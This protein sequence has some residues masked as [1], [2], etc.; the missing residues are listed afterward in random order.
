MIFK[1]RSSVAI[2]S[3]TLLYLCPSLRESL[4]LSALA[5]PTPFQSLPSGSFLS[6]Q[7]LTSSVP[8]NFCYQCPQGPSSALLDLIPLD[9]FVLFWKAHSFEN[10][11]SSF[12]ALILHSLVF[13]CWLFMLCPRSWCSSELHCKFSVLHTLYSLCR[14]SHFLM[15]LRLKPPSPP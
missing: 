14:E 5:V 11:F 3:A 8:Q 7:S 10:S 2:P 13:L 9:I 6:T 15:N 1:R 12:I 4:R